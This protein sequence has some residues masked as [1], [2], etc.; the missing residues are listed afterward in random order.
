MESAESEENIKEVRDMHRESISVCMACYNGEPYI[1]EQIASILPQL[2]EDDELII[3]DDHSSDS[4]GQIIQKMNDPRIRYM[5]NEKNL[6][7]NRSFEKAIKMA[8]NNYLFMA[9][10]DDL[11][12]EGRVEAML[13]K[14]QN[15]SLLVS[16]NSVSI[17]SNGDKSDYELGMLLQ[18]DSKA[19]GKN[20]LRIFTGKAYYYGCAMAFRRELRKVILPFPAYI[21]SHDLWIA[22][23]ANMLKSNAHL[24][25]I[26]LERRIHGKNASVLQRSLKEKLFSRWIFVKSYAALRRRFLKGGI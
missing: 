10:Q 22:M 13:Q 12:T 16:G 8:K 23:A 2:N 24:E 19:Y 18:E 11:W 21:E 4:T 6:G 7:V 3:I 17:D 26:V 15:G 20:I 25:K 5:F 9:D 1:E 14:L